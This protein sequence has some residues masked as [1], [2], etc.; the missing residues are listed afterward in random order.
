MDFRTFFLGLPKDAREAFAS[1]AATT[2]AYLAQVAYGNK[3]V[4]LGLA[5]VLCACSGWVV[6]LDGIPLTENAIRQRFIRECALRQR[7]PTA[8]ASGD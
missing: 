8:H 7:A 4:E 1:E 6:T 5:D 3:R 2:A